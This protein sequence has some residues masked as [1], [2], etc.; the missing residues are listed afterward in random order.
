MA[1]INNFVTMR[2]WPDLHRIALGV[3]ADIK[4]C[5]RTCNAIL[6]IIGQKKS[7][8]VAKM[9]IRTGMMSLIID[10]LGA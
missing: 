8:D 7:L 3:I 5:G 1:D 6:V 4:R 10:K 2:C 9:F